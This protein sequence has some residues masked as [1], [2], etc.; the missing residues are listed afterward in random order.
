MVEFFQGTIR[1]AERDYVEMSKLLGEYGWEVVN[2][3]IRK[4]SLGLG[5]YYTVD[6]ESLSVFTAT[7]DAVRRLPKYPGMARDTTILMPHVMLAKKTF[8]LGWLS[9]IAGG[10]ITGIAGYE[11]VDKSKH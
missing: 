10:T 5:I 11:L 2:G 6:P 4:V 3:V 9:Q 1:D 8:R 7:D